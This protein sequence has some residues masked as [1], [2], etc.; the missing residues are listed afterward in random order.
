LDGA[1]DAYQDVLFDA[2][3]LEREQYIPQLAY[4][5]ELGSLVDPALTENEWDQLAAYARW[6][7]LL[8]NA[9]Q[10]APDAMQVVYE[11]LQDK[12]PEGNPGHAYAAIA[13]AFWDSFQTT[14]DIQ[15]ACDAANAVAQGQILYPSHQVKNI[16][17]IP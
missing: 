16:C 6:R 14:Q 15:A 4:C 2:N 17:S 10:G 12:F 7:I 5:S 1:L 11:T 13:S 3:L 9:L 8:I